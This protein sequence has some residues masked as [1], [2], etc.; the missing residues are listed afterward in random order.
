MMNRDRAMSIL[1]HLGELKKRMIRVSIAFLIFTIIAAV[2][3]EQVFEFLRKPAE[4]ALADSEGQIIFT[5][6]AE[7]WGAAMKVAVILGFTAAMPYFLFELTMF[8]RG[9]L[10]PKERRYLYFFLPFSVLSF[11]VGVWFGFVVLIPPAI[12]FLLTFGSEL[13]TPFPTIGSYV[14][15]LIAL[16][17]WMGL[18]FEL[19]IVMFFLSKIGVVNSSWYLRQWRWMVLFAFILGAVVTP[20]FDPITQSLVAGPVIALYITGTALAKI[21]ER[22]KEDSESAATDSPT[23]SGS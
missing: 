9:G 23:G 12:N 3:Y 4:E 10:T 8:L 19:P 5:Q 1:E 6:V 11:A 13:A 17:F 22:G 18:I 20:T 7:A 21:A 14:G 2:F 15:L 16:S